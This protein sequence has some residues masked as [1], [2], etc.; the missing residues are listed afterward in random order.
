MDLNGS[1]TNILSSDTEIATLL[2][3]T[4]S[5]AVLGIKP[6]SHSSQPA[7]YVP[8]YMQ[9]V[10]YR[11][12]P[13]PVYYPDVS[14]ILGERVY[15]SVAEIPFEI[16]MVNVFRRPE[17]LKAH[18]DDILRKRPRSVWLQLGISN[19]QA[20]EIF[21]HSG[22]KVVRDLCLMVEHRALVA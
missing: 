22:I 1:N 7:F 14:R 11:I 8:Q 3:E 2:R 12:V 9:K 13:V 20:E 19:P 18:I 10:G 21:A 4:R 17:D 16:D 5:I 6:E 15:R